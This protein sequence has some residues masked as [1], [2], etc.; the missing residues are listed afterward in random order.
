MSVRSPL[1]GL[2]AVAA[3]LAFAPCASAATLVVDDD[4]VECPNRD[5]AT[6]QAA[7]NAAQ[8][9]D[10]VAVCP[11]VYREGTGLSITKA[12]TLKGSEREEAYQE[13]AKYIHEQFYTVPIGHP[14]FYYGLSSKLDWKPRLDAF[15]MVKEMKLK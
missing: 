14:N 8:A 4:A 6:I 2:F 5:A 3:L 9:D 10:T 15:I 1:A 13:I 12:L 7:V 11:G